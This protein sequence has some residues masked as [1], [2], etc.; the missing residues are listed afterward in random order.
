MDILF[1]SIIDDI[2]RRR[3]MES[4]KITTE[5]CI[6]E[7]PAQF[8]PLNDDIWFLVNNRLDLPDYVMVEIFAPDELFRTSKRDFEGMKVIGY[9]PFSDH[10]RINTRNYGSIFIPYRLEFVRITPTYKNRNDIKF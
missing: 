8:I 3:E 10:I 4:Y 6:V 1:Q 9:K 2:A 5:D 7:S